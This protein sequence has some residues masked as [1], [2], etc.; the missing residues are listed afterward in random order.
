VKPQNE[1][2]SSTVSGKAAAAA[3]APAGL[4]APIDPVG[5]ATSA[6]S[7]RR[8]A[9]RVP[10]WARTNECPSPSSKTAGAIRRQASQSM[11]VR[12]T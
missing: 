12:S 8:R 3:A 4:E 5:Q 2:F 9:W 10:G 6:M 7:A 11:Q 1:T